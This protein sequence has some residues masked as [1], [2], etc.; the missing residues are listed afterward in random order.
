MI[1]QLNN[2]DFV[3]TSEAYI[4]ATV[5]D[6]KIGILAGGILDRYEADIVSG[7]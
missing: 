1:Q 3:N 7:Q 6:K 2:P 5:L 4:L